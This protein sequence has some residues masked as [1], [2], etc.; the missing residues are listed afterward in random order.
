MPGSP[1]SQSSTK[2]TAE[3]PSYL[4][5]AIGEAWLKQVVKTVPLFMGGRVATI[6]A[7]ALG[8]LDQMKPEDDAGT[9]F[10]DGVLGGTKGA[11]TQKSFEAIGRLNTNFVIK[12]AAMGMTARTLDIGLNRETFDRDGRFALGQG[13]SKTFAESFSGKQIGADFAVAGLGYL[14]LRAVNGAGMSRLAESRLFGNI[15]AGTVFGASSGSYQE[16]SR[17]TQ[18]GIFDPLR[19]G[20]ESLIHGG[21]GAIAAAPGGLQGAMRYTAQD[22]G[23]YTPEQ[24]RANLARL[25]DP[26][27][28]LAPVK[29]RTNA[30]YSYASE[31]EFH[32]IGMGM[33]DRP[34]REYSMTGLPTKLQIPIEYDNQL[35]TLRRLRETASQSFGPQSALARIRLDVAGMRGH[36]LPEDLVPALDRMPDNRMVKQIQVFGTDSP[37]QMRVGRFERNVEA[38]AEM[39]DGGRL[40]FWRAPERFDPFDTVQHEWS[41]VQQDGNPAAWAAYHGALKVEEYGWDHHDYAKRNVRENWAVNSEPLLAIDRAKFERLVEMAPV[42]ATVLGRALEETLANVPR[43]SRAANYDELVRRTQYIRE[44][45]E[46]RARDI[47]LKVNATGQVSYASDVVREFL[48]GKMTKERAQKALAHPWEYD[49]Y[50]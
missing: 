26:V 22:F 20:K 48:D 31:A 16:L 8:A 38:L 25:Q 15:F 33:F 32:N 17:Q 24:A 12:G 42:R 43:E 7:A 37:Y 9:Q 41:H 18:A 40:M 13:L 34:V 36:Y 29:D 50:R 3:K 46:P 27:E 45:A 14:G 35:P 4:D 39:L 19:I 6:G 21:L 28:K 5:A 47:L 30:K 2:E 49:W 10:V 1:E 11:L 44:H 23:P